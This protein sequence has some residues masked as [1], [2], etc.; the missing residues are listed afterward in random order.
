MDDQIN[1]NSLSL[2]TSNTTIDPIT[3]NKTLHEV[4][5]KD[6]KCYIRGFK[7]WFKTKQIRWFKIQ[8]RNF[9]KLN[10]RS[11]RLPQIF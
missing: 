9:Y 5:K 4:K 1:L 10:Q 2:N 7:S 11:F 8:Y 3:L 6:R